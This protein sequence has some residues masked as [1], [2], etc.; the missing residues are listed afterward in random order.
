MKKA[1]A[2]LLALVLVLSLGACG[3][4][5]SEAESTGSD[6]GTV[7]QTEESAAE[8]AEEESAEDAEAEEEAESAPEAEAPDTESAG[9]DINIAVLS[10][11]T[12]VGAVGL[13]EANENGE[14]VNHYNFTVESQNDSVTAGLIS[15]EY[16]IAAIA[17]NLAANLYS[18]TEGGVQICALNTY[19]V[20]Y[21]LENGDEVQS[22][23]DLA[24]RTIYAAG[25]G[26]NPEYVLKYI[27]T[28]NGLDPDQDV[29]IVFEDASEIQT[30]M[31]A[32]EIDLC[33]LPVPAATSVLVQNSD[34]RS[35]LD[36]TEEWNNVTDEGQLTMGCIVVRTEFAQEH[37]EAV[38][39]FLEEYADSINSVLEDNEHAAELCE[40]Y[41]IVAK[42]AI[43]LKAIPDCSLCCV[44]G[45]EIQSVIEPYY[46]VLY[47]ANPDSIGGAMPGSDFYYVAG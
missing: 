43:A 2:L 3:S 14:T 31:A 47:D 13:M 36:L 30:K 7:S 21:I 11:P 38:A 40:T 22:V 20:L 37:P 24:G 1:I 23:S 8:T 6:A 33:M 5:S 10:G 16:D 44:T 9:T 41:E 29:E 12:G 19:G 15:G 26:A 39:T 34:V 27:L 42:A 45:S 32:G 25:Q 17:T 18:K 46:T 28:E 4:A 35:A